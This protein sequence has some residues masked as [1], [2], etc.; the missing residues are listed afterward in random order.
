ML[1][2]PPGAGKGTQAERLVKKFGL[3]HLSSGDIFRAEK[4][5]DSE[6]GAALARYMDAGELVPDDVVVEMMAKAITEVD[7]GLMLDGFPRTVAQAEALDKQ[8][9]E[10]DRPLDAVVVMT[11]DDDIIVKRIAG[12]RACPICGRGY[13]VTFMPPKREGY[14]DDCDGAEL[15]QRSDDCEATVRQRLEAYRAQTEAV[16]G[17]YRSCDSLSIVDV[18]GNLDAE[19]V[20]VEV[21]EALASFEAQA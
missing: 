19:V 5:S 13:H 16:I 15:T 14:C 1:M 4:A 10:A 9:V 12:R 18:D 17:Y 3:K 2:G 11:A 20:S 21:I 7:G 8:L 6:L